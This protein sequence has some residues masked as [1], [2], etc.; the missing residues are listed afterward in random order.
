MR[1]FTTLL[2]IMGLVLC[3]FLAFAAGT[4]TVGTPVKTK[5]IPNDPKTEKR[6]ITITWVASGSDASIGSATINAKTSEI[7]GWYLF[8]ADIV[9]GDTTAT[10]DMVV[11]DAYTADWSG[12][13]LAN[14]GSTTSY[15]FGTSQYGYKDVKGNLT[16][17]ITNNAQNSATGSVVLTFVPE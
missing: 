16:L 11:G 3:P 9:P 8:S 2:L 6:K 13:G 15:C 14:F 4:L 12:G 5:A 1:R 7:E 10:A 17:T